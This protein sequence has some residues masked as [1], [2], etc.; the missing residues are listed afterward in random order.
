MQEASNIDKKKT[1]EIKKK[2]WESPKTIE[3]STKT[4]N[5]KITKL[6]KIPFNAPVKNLL[7]IC[8]T[9]VVVACLAV[10]YSLKSGYAMPGFKEQDKKDIEKMFETQSDKFDIL[11]TLTKSNAGSI[12]GNTE[13]IKEINTSID[14]LHPI[15]EEDS[16]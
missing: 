13:A 14:R 5:G 15:P 8:L 1:E 9:L 7:I 11:L 4:R 2:F 10:V 3:Q 16:D 6:V 12:K